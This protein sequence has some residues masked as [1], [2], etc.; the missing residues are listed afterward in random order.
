MSSIKS[1]TDFNALMRLPLVL[2]AQ[3]ANLR[4]VLVFIASC[5]APCVAEGLMA[6]LVR[7]LMQLTGWAR[8]VA[9]ARIHQ[10]LR[11]FD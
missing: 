7:G 2:L 10:M 4:P 6:L 5:A 9:T 1:T 8:E 3:P 11:D